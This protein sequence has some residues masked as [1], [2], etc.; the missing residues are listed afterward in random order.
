MTM[1]IELQSIQS[2]FKNFLC[3]ERATTAIEYAMIAAGIS[4]AILVSVNSVGSALI[5]NFYDRITAGLE[6]AAAPAP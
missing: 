1:Q 3:D 5:S 6:Q 2:H 4:M